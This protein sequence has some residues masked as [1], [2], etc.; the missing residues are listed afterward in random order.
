MPPPPGPIRQNSEACRVG[1]NLKF[2][3]PGNLVRNADGQFFR[4]PVFQ[5]PPRPELP[6]S[7][8]RPV[9]PPSSR[10][11]VGG[12]PLPDA[13]TTVSVQWNLGR[14]KGTTHWARSDT[15]WKMHKNLSNMLGKVQVISQSGQPSRKATGKGLLVLKLS[16]LKSECVCYC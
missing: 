5:P 13:G 10:A 4:F 1:G 6:K 2:W 14:P 3:N 8:H 7:W 11:A 12:H 9:T 15:R 16:V